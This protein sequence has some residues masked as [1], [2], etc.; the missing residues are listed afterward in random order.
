MENAENF[1]SATN[2]KSNDLTNFVDSYSAHSSNSSYAETRAETSLKGVSGYLSSRQPHIME[3]FKK[4]NSFN[5]I[6]S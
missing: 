3:S 5:G 4:I 6:F 1:R 2:L